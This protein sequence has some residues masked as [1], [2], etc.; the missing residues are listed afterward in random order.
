MHTF[1]VH[2]MQPASAATNPDEGMVRWSP[3]KSLWFCVFFV[4]A[5]I[6]G[7]YTFSWSAV[8]VSFVLGRWHRFAKTGF[9]Q[10]PSDDAFA[11]VAI[12]LD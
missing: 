8:L 6:G 5:I 2:R 7:Y 3:I 9:K 4:T 1:E 10:R 12:L 11:Q